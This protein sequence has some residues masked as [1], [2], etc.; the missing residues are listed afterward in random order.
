MADAAAGQVEDDRVGRRIVA[1]PADQLDHRPAAA[2]ASAT[3]DADPPAAIAPSAIR[4][5][6]D[7][8]TTITA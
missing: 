8:M 1:R 2:A 3:R 5:I 6:G 4:P 7:P